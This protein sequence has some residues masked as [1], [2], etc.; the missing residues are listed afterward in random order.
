MLD[1]AKVMPGRAADT[2]Q[3]WYFITDNFNRNFSEYYPELIES[4]DHIWLA[5]NLGKQLKCL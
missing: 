3:A 2:I 1:T 5:K 4:D